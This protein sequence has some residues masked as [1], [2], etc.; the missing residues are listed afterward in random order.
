MH[1]SYNLR[2]PKTKHMLTIFKGV[3][4]NL[5]AVRPILVGVIVCAHFELVQSVWFQGSDLHTL[6]CAANIIYEIKL[7]NMTKTEYP[8]A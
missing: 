5:L 7:K 4:L 6:T 1:I 3:T 8:P 2:R